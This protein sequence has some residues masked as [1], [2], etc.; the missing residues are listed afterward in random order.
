MAQR[1]F[2]YQEISNL[3]NQM[4]TITGDKG[5]PTSIAGILDQVNLDYT[6]VVQGVVGEDEMA[7]FGELGQQMLLNW[8]NT[9]ANFPNFVENFGAWSTLVAQAAGDYSNFEAQVKGI[10]TASPLGWAAGTMTDSFITTSTYANA[11]TDQEIA[12]MAAVSKFHQLTGATY[13]DTGMVSY[14]RTSDIFEGVELALDAFAI[15]GGVKTVKA[16]LPQIKAASAMVTPIASSSTANGF[17]TANKGGG[18]TSYVYD[19]NAPGAKA[20]GVVVKNGES[21]RRVMTKTG[22]AWQVG[23]GGTNKISRWFANIT[24][25][26]GRGYEFLGNALNSKA[27]FNGQAVGVLKESFNVAGLNAGTVGNW[28]L[29]AAGANAFG[30]VVDVSG[31][32]IDA[33]STGSYYT[34]L[35]AGDQVQ[36]GDDSYT[37]FAQGTNGTNIVADEKGNLLYCDSAGD[38]KNVTINTSGGLVNATMDNTD[39]QSLFYAGNSTL[40]KANELTYAIVAE[41]YDAYY[42]TLDANMERLNS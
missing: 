36:I 37:F 42:D 19:N 30:R 1:V 21:L 12:D 27:T 29:A 26:T 28:G 41:D 13:I 9:S 6:D 25:K 23:K 24:N 4:N 22:D 15:Y 8:E 38:M 35:A 33:N 17:K 32:V 39:D 10:Q 14:L 40:G 34:A 16:L 5:D 7:L 11:Y 2:D 20:S 31:N 18:R 3:Y